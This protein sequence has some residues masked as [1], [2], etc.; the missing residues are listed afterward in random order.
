[1]REVSMTRWISKKA[2]TSDAARKEATKR[3]AAIR[4]GEVAE[5][6]E[7]TNSVREQ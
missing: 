6:G 1:M 5:I 4:S 3:I 7:P 2:A